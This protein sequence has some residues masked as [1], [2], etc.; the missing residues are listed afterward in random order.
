M[1]ICIML[2]INVKNYF[3]FF[4]LTLVSVLNGLTEITYKNIGDYSVRVF[5]HF[6][7]DPSDYLYHDYLSISSNNPSIKLQWTVDQKARELFDTD[8]EEAKKVYGNSPTVEIIAISDQPSDGVIHVDYYQKSNKKID[9]LSIPV[10][11]HKSVHLDKQNNK[12]LQE[13]KTNQQDTSNFERDVMA[14][15]EDT[16][17]A[18]W[19]EYIEG[20]LSKTESLWIRVLFA[21]LLGL[22]LSLT[23]CVYP[24]IPITV[25]ILQTQGSRS[26]LRNFLLALSYTIGIATTYALLGLSAAFTG[27]IFGSLLSQPFFVFMIVA[28]L[29]YL[30]GSMIGFYEMYIPSFLTSGNQMRGGGSILSAFLF[31]AVA[32]TIASPCLSPGLVLLLTLVTAIGNKLIGFLLLFSFGV[33]L[34]I[35]LLIIGTFSSSL[36]ILPS[37]GLWMVEIKKMFGFIMIGMCFFYLKML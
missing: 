31:G 20:L 9:S 3:I 10:H 23:P 34:S 1:L 2:R 28:L 19:R 30:A 5:I 4:I 15:R 29:L 13:N 18:S 32:G 14:D 22:L 7:L 21:L 11:I 6:Q 33:G 37:A 16:N 36:S 12:S 27:Q 17:V 26:V 8:F 35:P 24:M 25:G